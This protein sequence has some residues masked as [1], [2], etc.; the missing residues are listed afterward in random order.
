MNI[1]I[2]ILYCFDLLHYLYVTCINIFGFGSIGPA[3]ILGDFNFLF[4]WIFSLFMYLFEFGLQTNLKNELSNRQNIILKKYY[5]N[6]P[7][8]VLYLIIIRICFLIINLVM[9]LLI[10]MIEFKFNSSLSKKY[11][12]LY[13]KISIIM[14]TFSL[15]YLIKDSIILYLLIIK[16]NIYK[17]MK[18]ISNYSCYDDEKKL[19]KCLDNENIIIFFTTNYLETY[20]WLRKKQNYQDYIVDLKYKKQDDINF[21]E[22]NNDEDIMNDDDNLI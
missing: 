20:Y 11:N 3:V 8:W 4:L 17:K 2:L 21:Y 7:K 9:A 1:P 12:D 5:L 13:N 6:L 16:R 10:Y 18:K 19:I 15:I 22:E 14:V